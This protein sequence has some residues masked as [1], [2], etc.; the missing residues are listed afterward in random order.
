[1]RFL[2]KWNILNADKCKNG[3][4]KK[5]DLFCAENMSI[6]EKEMQE[7]RDFNFNIFWG[8]E[9]LK[10]FVEYSRQGTYRCI[11]CGSVA[12]TREHVPSKTFLKKPLPT[13]LPVL[14]ACKK[15]N[16]GFS[17]DELYTKTYIKC[18]KAVLIDNNLGYLNIDCSDRKEIREA[19]LSIKE[20]LDQ[21]ELVYDARV[22]RVLRKLA[23]GHAVYELSEGYPSLTWGWTPFYTKYIMRSTVSEAEWNDL[24]YAEAMNDKILPEMG[25]RVFRN[26]FAIQL[27]LESFEGN[28]NLS[29]NL[30]L[31]DWTDIQ[32]GEY[33]YVAYLDNTNQLV[34][35]MIIMD[36]L[37]GEVVFRR[38]DSE[39]VKD[40]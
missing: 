18:L 16:N 5:D 26:L 13:D 3:A 6:G 11:Y 1:M 20:V 14:P 8:P 37:Y 7:G 19:K 17:S 15:C 25:S 9:Y 33:R 22:G 29:F 35:K 12:D 4:N 32:D 34:V 23:I 27:P 10:P 28:S 2:V 38:S 24:E 36:F 21:K 31:L 30:F 40:K 39:S